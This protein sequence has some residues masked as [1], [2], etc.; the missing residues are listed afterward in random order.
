MIFVDFMS[1][2]SRRYN[3]SLVDQRKGISLELR[4]R[5]MIEDWKENEI[6]QERI[7]E[8]ESMNEGCLR[9]ESPVRCGD[10]G[11]RLL[12]WRRRKNAMHLGF[13]I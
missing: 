4:N 3:K 9:S 12:Q 6:H 11:I 1:L 7:A 13:G 8:E 2:E 10:A 5:D